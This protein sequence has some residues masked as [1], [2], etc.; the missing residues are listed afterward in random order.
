[1]PPIKERGIGYA[2]EDFYPVKFFPLYSGVIIKEVLD[3]LR[4][5]KKLIPLPPIRGKGKG[6]ISDFS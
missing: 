5:S 2:R 3:G 6:L 4:P 1:V